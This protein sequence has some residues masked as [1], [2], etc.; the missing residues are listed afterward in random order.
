[1][2]IHSILQKLA[3]EGISD[4]FI[5]AG[6]PIAYKVHGTIKDM[7]TNKMS[8]AATE[9]LIKGIYQL[10]NNR[11]INRLKENGD[12]DFSFAINGVARYRVSAY[13]QR[14]SLAAV[15]RVISFEIPD[16]HTLNIPEE[17]INLGQDA[18]GLTLITGPADSGKSTTLACIIDMINKTTCKNIITFEDPIEYLHSHNKSK[19]SQ[20]EINLDTKNLVTS[21]RAALRQSPDVLLLGEMRDFETISIAMTAAETG[22]LLLSTLHTMGASNTI[23]RIIDVFPANQQRQIAIQ[24]STTLNAV[25]SQQLLPTVTGGTVPAFEIMTVTP[26]IRN[27]IRDGK[28]FQ[29]DGTIFSANGT[30]GMVSMDK[31]I[32]K[33]YQDGIISK[34]TMLTYSTN[35]DR[36]SF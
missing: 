19:I 31:S 21:L 3:E 30:H 32:Q 6:S 4:V 36:I 11:D 8:P 26:A 17:I 7:D 34:E 24:L 27:M 1:M 20:R 12:D 10:A 23:N 33:L 16:Y 5:I 13:I 22:H 25:V 14:G 28:I 18:S 29:L 35:P 2:E 15:L 9:E